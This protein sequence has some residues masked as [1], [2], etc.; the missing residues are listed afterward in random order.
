MDETPQTSSAPRGKLTGLKRRQLVVKANKKVF[1]WVAGAALIVTTCLVVSQFFVRQLIYNNKVIDEKTQTNK[2]IEQ[3]KETIKTVK[4][5]I[6]AMRGNENLSAARADKQNDSNF[7][8]I[9]D[10]LPAS[11]DAATFS[12]SLAQT[13]LRPANVGI[14]ALSAGI[15]DGQSASVP[16]ASSVVS[17]G[18]AISPA[19]MPFMVTYSGSLESFKEAFLRIEKT[20]RPIYIT[21]FVLSASDE[22][23]TINITGK[24]FYQ[25]GGEIKLGQKEIPYEKK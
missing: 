8:V 10:A 18:E 20:I 22:T 2:T 25:P 15:V 3:N 6:D 24:T 16:V 9:L 19:E 23:T 13:I 4:D 21:N 5:K 17:T 12:N 11:E 7:Q 1:L 14:T